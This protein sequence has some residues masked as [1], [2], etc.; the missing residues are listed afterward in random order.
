M[1]EYCKVNIKNDFFLVSAFQSF[2]N[3]CINYI[4]TN[5]NDKEVCKKYMDEI[6][7]VMLCK[8]SDTRTALERF[9]HTNIFTKAVGE[10]VEIN[11]IDIIYKN[12]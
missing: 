10:V 1:N 12:S 11:D 7:D 2:I 8:I 4:Y 9:S 3:I 5:V 6:S